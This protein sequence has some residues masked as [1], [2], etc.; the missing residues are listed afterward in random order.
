MAQESDQAG[1]AGVPTN[2]KGLRGPWPDTAASLPSLS[3]PPQAGEGEGGGRV[4]RGPMVCHDVAGRGDSENLPRRQSVGAP[5]SQEVSFHYL[6]SMCPTSSPA[7][8]GHQ[9]PAGQASMSEHLQQPVFLKDL[10]QPF[11]LKE[12]SSLVGDDPPIDVGHL[13][14][15]S[16]G[17][18]HLE[19]QV[20]ELFDR[21]AE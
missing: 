6:F 8:S 14:R 5:S 4:E 10:H 20:L 18:R 2:R 19:L 16:L 21:Q 12:S 1:L 17:D 11:F 9:Y 3:P 13:A 15:T 7:E